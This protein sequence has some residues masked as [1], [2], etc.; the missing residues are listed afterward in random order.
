[1]RLLSG[2]AHCSLRFRC[3]CGFSWMYDDAGC[4]MCPFAFV[5]LFI[6][7]PAA[8]MKAVKFT[9]R[10]IYI[11]ISALAVS[12]LRFENPRVASSILAWA[13]THSASKKR[14][15]L[16]LA[17]FFPNLLAFCFFSLPQYAWPVILLS[18]KSGFSPD[19]K[20][21]IWQS[22][23]TGAWKNQKRTGVRQYKCE[24]G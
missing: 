23:G 12:V 19:Q 1:M 18:A 6:R 14:Q 21:Q 2:S 3:S 22:R 20:N 16:L 5:R 9:N 10:L 13:T 24:S 11:N 4:W 17:F 15:H 8:L 7:T